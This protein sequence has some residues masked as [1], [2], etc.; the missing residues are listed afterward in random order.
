MKINKKY[1]TSS[2]KISEEYR[3]HRKRMNKMQAASRRKNR[4]RR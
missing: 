1:P 3:K 4:K 2:S